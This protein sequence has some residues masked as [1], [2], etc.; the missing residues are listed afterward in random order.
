MVF[1]SGGTHAWQKGAG[2]SGENDNQAA[3][4]EADERAAVQ[5]AVRTARQADAKAAAGLLEQFRSRLKWFVKFRLGGRISSRVDASDVVQDTYLDASRQLDDLANLSSRSLLNVLKK[6]AGRRAVDSYRRHVR[7]MRRSV[8]REMPIDGPL[9]N[10]SDIR[11]VDILPSSTS[12]P[13]TKASRRDLLRAMR[14]GLN[15]LSANDR[16]LLEMRHL[17]QRSV[18]E[19]AELLQTSRGVVTSRHL[20]ALRRLRRILASELEASAP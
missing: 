1:A 9:A 2:V 16:Q 14:E 10:N 13:A 19:I 17:Q 18:E 6:M 15:K 7:A 11:L 8:L 3:R 5:T 4:D 12:T 20:R